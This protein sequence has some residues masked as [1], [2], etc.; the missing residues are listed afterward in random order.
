M[1]IRKCYL[2]VISTFRR[3]TSIQHQTK[4]PG[5]GYFMVNNVFTK[6]DDSNLACK[7]L[8]EQPLQ[9]PDPLAVAFSESARKEILSGVLLFAGPV[10]LLSCRFVGLLC[11]SL[12][13]DLSNSIA[14]DG[15]YDNQ[16]FAFTPSDSVKSSLISTSTQ[17]YRRAN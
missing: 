10:Q 3:L 4:V 9:N 17:S 15:T 7:F 12:S 13:S 11:V 8:V 1:E 2:H 16:H 14:N 6:A 5:L